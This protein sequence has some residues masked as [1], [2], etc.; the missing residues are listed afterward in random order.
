MRQT[1]LFLAAL[2]ALATFGC[3]RR[4]DDVAVAVSVIGDAPVLRSPAEGPLTEPSRV[5]QPVSV[6][7]LSMPRTARRLA[8]VRSITWSV[9]SCECSRAAAVIHCV[10]WS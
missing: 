7:R 3:D 1:R 4:P 8:P 5:S 9:R 2:I 6:R 10:K